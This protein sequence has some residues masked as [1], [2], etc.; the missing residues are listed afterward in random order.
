MMCMIIVVSNICV[1]VVKKQI[2]TF[3]RVISEVFIG[4]APE[5]TV[6]MSIPRVA[7]DN[8]SHIIYSVLLACQPTSNRYFSLILN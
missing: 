1:I 3:E 6:Y 2:L 4:G 8:E 7:H 5:T